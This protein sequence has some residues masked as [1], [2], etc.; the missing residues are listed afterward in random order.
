MKQGWKSKDALEK[1]ENGEIENYA[2]FPD[3]PGCPESSF[4][5][6]SRTT[7]NLKKWTSANTNTANKAIN[8]S[9]IGKHHKNEERADGSDSDEWRYRRCP[10]SF[11]RGFQSFFKPKLFHKNI[12]K[13][14]PRVSITIIMILCVNNVY[15]KEIKIFIIVDFSLNVESG[16]ISNCPALD[17]ELS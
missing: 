5:S 10:K 13:L 12:H 9:H 15:L 16:G 7:K 3:W 14:Y 8:M 1:N 2:K 17:L 6:E 11:R 4:N